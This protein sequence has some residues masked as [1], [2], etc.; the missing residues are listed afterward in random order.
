MNFS[1]SKRFAFMVISIII[2]AVLL[3]ASAYVNGWS[4]LTYLGLT[5]ALSG[6]LV[7]MGLPF[8]HVGGS[9][10]EGSDPKGNKTV[11]WLAIYAVLATIIGIFL[12]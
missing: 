7:S 11:V 5:I 8:S 1:Q 4:L 12:F 6:L 10:D 2:G 3:T 9:M